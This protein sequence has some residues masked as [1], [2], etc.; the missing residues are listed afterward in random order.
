M[1]SKFIEKIKLIA[2]K[3]IKRFKHYFY[4][5]LSLFYSIIKYYFLYFNLYIIEFEFNNK[6]YLI[7]NKEIIIIFIIKI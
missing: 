7:Y 3:C 5:I 6:L 2:V 4:E 1:L